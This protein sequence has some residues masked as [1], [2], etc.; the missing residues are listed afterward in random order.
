[1]ETLSDIDSIL[2][3]KALRLFI[4]KGTPVDVFKKLTDA[5]SV[6]QVTFERETVEPYGKARDSEVREILKNRK[7]HLE[8]RAT[9]TLYDQHFLWEKNEFEIPKTYNG[10][11]GIL[12]TNKLMP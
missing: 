9:H 4:A 10:F 1:M 6:E 8:T 5:Y 2:R 12:R 11:L 7:V 3:E